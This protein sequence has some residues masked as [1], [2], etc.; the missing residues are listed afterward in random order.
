M[1]METERKF[2]VGDSAAV[3]DLTAIPG[4]ALTEPPVTD[5]LEASYFDTGRLDLAVRGITLRRRTGGT[6]DGWHLK[7]PAGM[8]QQGKIHEPLGQPEKVPDT[9]K[10]RLLV[11]TRGRALQRVARISTERTTHRLHDEEGAHIAD[12]SDDKVH[13]EAFLPAGLTTQW[14]QWEMEAAPGWDSILDAAAE[15]LEAAGAS[16]SEHRAKLAR[17]FGPRWPAPPEAWRRAPRKKGPVEAVA[18]AYVGD[19]IRTLLELDHG[20]RWEEPDAVHQMRSTTRRVRSGLATYKT[21]FTKS[22]VRDLQREL[23]WLAGMLGAVR[24]AEVLRTRI[25]DSIRALPEAHGTGPLFA[26]VEQDLVS[27]YDA[28]YRQLVRTLGSDRYFR[29][30]DALESFRDQ[31]PTKAAGSRPARKASPKL[32]NK[33]A[34]R[35]DRAQRAAAK[36]DAGEQRD[37]ALH[38]IRKD[39]KRLRFAAESVELI[40]GKPARKLAKSAKGLQRILGEH[41]DSVIGRAYLQDIATRPGLPA[42]AAAASR[43]LSGLEDQKAADT[44]AQYNKARGKT[45]KARLQ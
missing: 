4:V 33:V 37:V 14:R 44:E 5:H 19:Q 12:L 39:A 18:I 22:R 41:Q 36:A 38:Q 16:P 7:M 24:D 28:A 15:T 21:L 23:K 8:D 6:D 1:K 34:K 17:T 40:H 3:P 31:P 29:L 20:V 27:S 45:Y 43:T 2:D 42:D 30:L 11:Y 32:V 26:A 13:A 9:L 35:L 10:D 25:L